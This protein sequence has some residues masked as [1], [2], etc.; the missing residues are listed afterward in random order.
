M[1]RNFI[2]RG[3]KAVFFV[4]G[5][6]WVLHPAPASSS[7]FY[8]P[9]IGAKTVGRGAAWIA[10]VDDLTA[11]YLNPAG[12]SQVKGTNLTVINNFMTLRT[13]YKRSPIEPAV[14][15]KNPMDVIQFFG[16][17]SDFGLRRLTF[18][19][20]LYGP[21]GV[22]E[23]Y[24][25]KGPQR[26]ESTDIQ[27]VQVY[28]VAGVGWAPLRWLRVGVTGGVGEFQEKDTYAFSPFGDGD[29]RYDILAKVNIHQIGNMAFGF[30]IK[31]GP[32]AGFEIG[33][34]YEPETDLRLEGDVE[35]RLPDLYAAIVGFKVY[36]DTIVV[37]CTLPQTARLGVRQQI[38][39]RL[40]LEADVVWTGW[41]VLEAQKVDLKK[42]ELMEDM[43]IPIRWRDTWSFR[44][45]GEYVLYRSLAVRAGGWYDQAATRPVTLRPGAVEMDRWA[46]CAGVG[47]T[48][49]GITLDF[50]Y[51]HIW[52]EEEEV[53]G[54][55]LIEQEMGD[56]RGKYWASSDL[57]V[58]GMNL[59]FNAIVK[60]FKKE[61]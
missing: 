3:L 36:T 40:D 6:L 54:D 12:L 57:F 22:A 56:A 49:K 8:T 30:G 27:R 50:G 41:S 38:T 10:G 58:V 45:G 53:T 35:A 43:E 34:S 16:I 44:L 39:E 60:A 2:F 48:W 26:Y 24:N 9:D 13:R 20:G 7:G 1:K 17:S 28:Y 37:T 42:E 19:I 32:F 18:G 33:A 46:A 61:K 25:E 51:T 21:Y 59:N 5:L 4:A 55:D 52:Y 11:L 47:Y 23:S 14:H 15:N 31:L 29:P